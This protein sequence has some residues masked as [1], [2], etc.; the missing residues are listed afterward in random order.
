MKR[1][2][3]YTA[4]AQPELSSRHMSLLLA[5]AASLSV[6]PQDAPK[7]EAPKP[8]QGRRSRP[9]WK[10]S[11][12]LPADLWVDAT[13]ATLG[14]TAEWTNKVEIADLDAD[15]LP[16]LV[17]ANGGDYDARGELVPSRV[18]MNRGAGAKFEEAT[19][20]VFG[21]AKFFARV[22]KVRDVNGDGHAD[23]FVGATF[24]TQ[25][26]LFVGLGEGKFRDATDELLPKLPGST[27][28][29]E[30]GDVD[31]DGDLDL[32]L[33]EWG[34]GSPMKNDG[35]RTRLWLNDGNGRFTDVTLERMPDVL[36]RFSWELE[37]VDVDNDLDLDLV[38]SSKRSSGSFLFENDGA[39]KFRDATAGRLP[40]FTNNYEFEALDLDGDAVLDLV[41][42]NDGER[43]TEH[44]L[45]GDGKG[46]FE[47]VTER[48]WP[49][50][51]NPSFDDN[52]ICFLDYDSDGDADLLIGSLDGPDRLLVNDGKGKLAAAAPVFSGDD[53]RGT[54]GIAL[55]DLNG[56]HKLDVVHAQGENP[57]ATAE[58][59]FF[60]K[61]LAPDTAGPTV[62]AVRVLGAAKA[63]KPLTLVARVHDR[64]TPLAAHDFRRVVLVVEQGESKLELPLAWYGECLWRATLP[65]PAAGVLKAHVE[66]VDAAGNSTVGSRAEFVIE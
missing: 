61:S 57:K 4:R 64:K 48:W 13:E 29:A 58:K 51:D 9:E 35:G 38:I 62:G 39:G 60:G 24:S 56:D 43:F 45:R 40:Q 21:E 20:R 28:D 11:L 47:D 49:A 37:F 2:Q 42:I 50:A 33:A 22:V 55:A 8:S 26:G 18:F 19:A 30:F 34:D 32:V 66:A 7:P 59:V 12:T 16:D 52:M 6:L 46:G 27:G 23:V 65:A 41:T 10:A 44:V 1:T 53:T 15:G 36:V 17:F 14:A 54:L 25:S 31:G 5:F 63:G 3:G